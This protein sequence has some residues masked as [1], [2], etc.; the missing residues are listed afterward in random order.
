MNI[1]LFLGVTVVEL[2]ILYFVFRYMVKG[3]YRLNQRIDE[4]K[5]AEAAAADAAAVP[6]DVPERPAA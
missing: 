2:L 4:R 3:L 6:G 5:A 1:W